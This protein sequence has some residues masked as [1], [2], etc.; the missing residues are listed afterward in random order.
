MYLSEHYP[1][2]VK[3]TLLVLTNNEL[4][5]LFTCRE[6]DVDELDVITTPETAS[7]EPTPSAPA[8]IDAAKQHRR[9]ELYAA[10]SE[11]LQTLLAQ[12]AFHDIVLCVPEANK[13]E[14][15]NALHPDIAKRIASLV[16]KNL[17]SMELTQVLR[18]L[19]EA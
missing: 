4:A 9:V 6:R 1:A 11:R 8:S 13:N 7:E 19:F 10:L 16:P 3:P 18:I 2:F 14:L 5:R 15:V 17:A 12:K